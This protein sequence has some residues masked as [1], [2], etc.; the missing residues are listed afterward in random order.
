MI[1]TCMQIQ[2]DIRCP[3]F[4]TMQSLLQLITIRK[5]AQSALA[6]SSIEK[7]S[8]LKQRSNVRDPTKASLRIGGNTPDAT[9]SIF[10]AE[11]SVDKRSPVKTASSEIPPSPTSVRSRPAY[12]STNRPSPTVSLDQNIVTAWADY[13]QAHAI[14]KDAPPIPLALTI[15]ISVQPGFEVHYKIAAF[16]ICEL[17]AKSK[18]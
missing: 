10:N 15:G 8:P 4:L 6:R 14:P 18:K 1:Q 17:R 7:L 9:V 11:S 13:I 12:A 2:P 3:S 16:S 5:E